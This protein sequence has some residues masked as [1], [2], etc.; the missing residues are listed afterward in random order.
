[1]NIL[2]ADDSPISLKLVEKQAQKS[3]PNSIYTSTNGEEAFESYKDMLN[4]GLG[5]LVLLLDINMPALNG[6]EVIKKVRAHERS[7]RLTERARIMV[8][9]DYDT[10]DAEYLARLVG[11]DAFLAKT[12]TNNTFAATLGSFLKRS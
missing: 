11:A 12:D 1:M 10:D 8:I 7:Q 3:N 4:M 9:T 5:D 2:I 6:I